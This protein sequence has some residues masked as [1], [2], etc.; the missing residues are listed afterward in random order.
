M[1]TI[2]KPLRNAIIII[3][4]LV[5]AFVGFSIGHWLLPY[6]QTRHD[7]KSVEVILAD[8]A[9]ALNQKAP[10]SVDAETRLDGA[11]VLDHEFRYRYTLIHRIAADVSARTIEREAGKKLLNNLCNSSDMKTFREN[12]VTV[13]YAYF[14]KDGRQIAQISASPSQCSQP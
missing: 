5:C 13:V 8:T 4:L 1:P 12:D 7:H 3:G 9:K 14:G 11:Q 10:I 6:F 2:S